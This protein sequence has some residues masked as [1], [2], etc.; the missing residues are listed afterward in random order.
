MFRTSGAEEEYESATSR[1]SR[2][3]GSVGGAGRTLL[4]W[5]K[6]ERAG[7]TA[8]PPTDTPPIP[9]LG[10]GSAAMRGAESPP[11]NTPSFQ[12]AVDGRKT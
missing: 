8:A 6:E 2:Q 11:L 12:S 7:G 1:P 9:F 5:A 3:M 10:G 4:L